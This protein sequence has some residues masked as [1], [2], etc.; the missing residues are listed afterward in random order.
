MCDF[1]RVLALFLD[2]LREFH[3]ERR[4]RNA[5]S[6]LAE[7]EEEEEEE[8][9]WKGFR[10]ND[11]E[12][13]SSRDVACDRV[14]FR[15]EDAAVA[16]RFNWRELKL[17]SFFLLPLFQARNLL[18]PDNSSSLRLHRRPS[19][20]KKRLFLFLTA[21]RR[22]FLLMSLILT[23]SAIIALMF[24]YYRSLQLILHYPPLNRP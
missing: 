21:T 4:V 7:E 2:S 6:C 20:T 5:K 15:G 11:I 24:H 17:S 13:L 12:N 14:L 9:E 19:V 3:S 23:T 16:A 1:A 8:E 22:W 18:A 10:G